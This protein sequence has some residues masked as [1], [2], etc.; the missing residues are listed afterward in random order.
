[1]NDLTN[2]EMEDLQ[3]AFDDIK[4]GNIKTFETVEDLLKDLNED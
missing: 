2:K 4:Q 3:E 1:M